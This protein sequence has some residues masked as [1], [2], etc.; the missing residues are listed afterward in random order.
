MVTRFGY[1]GSRAEGEWM[2]LDSKDSAKDNPSTAGAD[3]KPHRT[4]RILASPHWLGVSIRAAE[5]N[6][7]TFT[8]TASHQS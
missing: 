3:G 4:E 7:A 6:P 5:K 8:P 2:V 1:Y